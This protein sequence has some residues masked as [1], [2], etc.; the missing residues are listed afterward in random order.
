MRSDFI[1]GVDLSMLQQ[2]EANN[3]IYRE[4]GIEK[5]A[6]QI[7]KDHNIN[8][9]RLRLWHAPSGGYDNL[10]KTLLMASRIKSFGFKFLLNFHYSDT[11]AD[12]AQQTK[13]TAWQNLSFQELKDS[14]YQY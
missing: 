11:W 12:P 4:N 7:F 10:E 8:F 6:L 14:V 1:R 3:G 2:I 9:V 5:D 13:P